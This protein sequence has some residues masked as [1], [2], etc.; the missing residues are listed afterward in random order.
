MMKHNFFEEETTMKDKCILAKRY[1]LD[2]TSQYKT[3]ENK[4]LWYRIIHIK[5]KQ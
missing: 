4:L 2:K 1:V 3:T 5:T